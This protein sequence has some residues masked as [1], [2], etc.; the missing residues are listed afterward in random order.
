MQSY[1]FPH[2]TVFSQQ[3]CLEHIHFLKILQEPQL[4]IHKTT[5][6]LVL[7]AYSHS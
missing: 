4:N 7:G 3:L 6:L 1:Q 2:E 5:Q